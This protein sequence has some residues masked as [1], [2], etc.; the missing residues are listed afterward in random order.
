MR[1]ASVLTKKPMS[2]SSSVRV[3]FATGV[4]MTTSL[5][6]DR[7]ASSAAQAASSVMNSVVP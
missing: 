2:G 4:P 1:R 5:W 6:P 3:R 7:R